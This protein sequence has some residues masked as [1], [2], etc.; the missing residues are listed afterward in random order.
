MFLFEFSVAQWT[1]RHHRAKIVSFQMVED[2]KNTASLVFLNCSNF[3]CNFYL[4]AHR[5]RPSN[6]HLQNVFL[7][8]NIFQLET[9]IIENITYLIVAQILRPRISIRLLCSLVCF[10]CHPSTQDQLSSNHFL[11][12]QSKSMVKVSLLVASKETF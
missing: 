9:V 12:I 2:S 1:C 11:T 5:G 8:I 6:S 3:L 7:S 4:W 10:R